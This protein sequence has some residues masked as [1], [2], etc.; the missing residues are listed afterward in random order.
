MVTK[1]IL[2]SATSQPEVCR[3]YYEETLGL[4]FESE[5]PFA[6]VFDSGEIEQ[7]CRTEIVSAQ[8]GFSIS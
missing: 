8:T 6:V 3:K 2:F 1:P 4:R 5:F 7:I